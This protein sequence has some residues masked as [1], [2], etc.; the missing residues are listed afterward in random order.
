MK[1]VII[2]GDAAGM[3]AAMQIVRNDEEADVTTLEMGDT[4][5]YAQ[6]GLPYAISGT[7]PDMDKLIARPVEVFREKYGIDARIYHKVTKVDPETK[8]VYGIALKTNEALQ[9]TYDRLLIATGARPIV[10]NWNGTELKGVHTLKTI[11][12]AKEIVESAKEAKR[13]TVIGGGYIGLEMAET[14]HDLG[15]EVRIIQRGSQL[16][17]TFDPD[18][19]SHILDE[20]ERNGIAVHLE[21]T[22]TSLNGSNFVE[23]VETDKNTY[24]TDLVL[25]AIG[26]MPN[27]DF[28]DHT[29]MHKGVKN[30]ILV[31]RYME[32]SIKDIYAAGD[33][34]TQYNRLKKRDE[35]V[36]LGTHANKQGRI[37]GLNMIGKT[38]IFQGIVGTAILKFCTLALGRT[39]LTEHEAKVL[40]IPYETTSL[41]ATDIAG[42]YPGKER[43]YV[44]LL[45]HTNTK[46]VLGGQF[47]GKDGV[48]KR[49]DV[50]ATALYHGMT[51]HEL[52]DLDLSYA[53]PFNS[54]WDPIQ[55]GARRSK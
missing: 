48:A 31:N 15:K 17:N 29:D 51:I 14:F 26:V 24:E 20:A 18:M 2:G 38:R 35:F 7:I 4:Y 8:T 30:T 33:C 50:L 9:I 16:A 46:Q 22:V 13:V 27:T 40:N 3:S 12:D 55:Q 11:N 42:Y 28:I 53:P 49:T 10:P 19:A 41:K 25:I 45:Y 5:S 52:E 23:S 37:A 34:A 47:I 21:E 32:T 43:L 1:Y 44:K 39:G 36:P 54:V 6:C